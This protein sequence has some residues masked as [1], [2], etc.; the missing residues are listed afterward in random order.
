MTRTACRSFSGVRSGLGLAVALLLLLPSPLAAAPGWVREAISMPSTSPDSAAARVR[1]DSRELEF[2]G[3]GLWRE[4]H[5]RVVEIR[6]PETAPAA[7]RAIVSYRTDSM[8]LREFRAWLVGPDGRET[9]L[10]N[11]EAVEVAILDET[12]FNEGRRRVLTPTGAVQP[13]SFFA[14]ESRVDERTPFQEYGVVI[15]AEY[16]VEECTVSLR[17]RRDDVVRYW[18]RGV[19]PDSSSDGSGEHRWS[20][21]RLRGD[22]TAGKDAAPVTELMVKVVPPETGP[23]PALSSWVDVARWLAEIAESSPVDTAVIAGAAREAVRD[24]VS[25]DDSL[26]VLADLTQSV[27]YV[28]IAMGIGSGGGYRPRPAAQVLTTRYGDCKDKSNLMRALLSSP[29]DRIAPHGTERR[30]VVAGPSGVAVP[31]PLQSL[32]SRHLRERILGFQRRRHSPPLGTVVAVR[33]HRRVSAPGVPA[34]GRSGKLGASRGPGLRAARSDTGHPRGWCPRGPARPDERGRRRSDPRSP[35][36]D[37]DRHRGSAVP[38][39]VPIGPRNA[40]PERGGS[41]G[42]GGAGFR[43]RPRWAGGTRI[44]ADLAASGGIEHL[45]GGLL[46]VTPARFFS[47]LPYPAG[48]DQR[49]ATQGGE[50]RERLVLRSGPGLAVDAISDPVTMESPT[51]RFEQ[52]ATAGEIPW[53]SSGHSAWKR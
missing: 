38:C 14:W 29:R 33:S 39:G 37:R 28:S 36:R 34:G 17:T 43:G 19:A 8:Q 7:A 47:T 42:E 40:Q 1:W 12:I 2:R 25:L 26:R 46:L 48:M 41:S 6:D 3:D 24:A 22:S 11:D 49:A 23:I 27:R 10:G 4:W 18:T 31:S 53:S 21:R 13:G 15:S 5:R 44:E 35:D 30:S 51:G 50:W 20:Y 32:H 16:P 52:I 9:P 45:P